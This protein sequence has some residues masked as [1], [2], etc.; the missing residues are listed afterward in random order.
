MI[1]ANHHMN[2]LVFISFIVSKLSTLKLVLFCFGG[3]GGSGGLGF[4]FFC[5]VLGIHP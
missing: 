2:T 4:G 3:G 1:E 5:A